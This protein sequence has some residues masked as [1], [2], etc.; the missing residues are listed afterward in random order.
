MIRLKFELRAISKDNKKIFNKMGRPFTSAKYK[1][2]ERMI[3]LL[4]MNQYRGKLLEGDVAMTMTF[5]F[6]NKV[7]CDL[8][9]LAKSVADSL[10]SIVYKNDKQIKHLTM[11]LIENYEKDCFEITAEVME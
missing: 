7:H 11:A 1:Q 8:S 4:A 3:Q 9:N 5:Y 2:F 6:K 10:Q